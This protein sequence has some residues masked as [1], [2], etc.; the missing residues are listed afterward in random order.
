VKIAKALMLAWTLYVSGRP[1][2]DM[3]FGKNTIA[4]YPL[5]HLRSRA[6]CEGVRNME[7]Y[8]EQYD[9]EF[10]SNIKVYCKKG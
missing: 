8:R 10:V 3:L 9:N 5:A 7:A 6:L 1:V 2:T 4:E